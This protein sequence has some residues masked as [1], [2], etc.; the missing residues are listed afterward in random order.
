MFL[1]DYFW[2][3]IYLIIL[4]RAASSLGSGYTQPGPILLQS[5]RVLI[6][7]NLGSQLAGQVVTV[8]LAVRTLFCL[9]I[10]KHICSGQ[11]LLSNRQLLTVFYHPLSIIN[12]STRNSSLFKSFTRDS[13][14]AS[15]ISPAMSAVSVSGEGLQ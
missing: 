5:N 1:W 8:T 2:K 7:K 3:K 15:F 10:D 6:A 14:P 9:S 4:D 13:S 12:S 11:Y